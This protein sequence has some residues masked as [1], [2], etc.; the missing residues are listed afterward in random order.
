[1]KP[2][3]FVAVTSVMLCIIIGLLAFVYWTFRQDDY[4]KDSLDMLYRTEID[5]AARSLA[6]ALDEN[7]A[8]LAYYHAKTAAENAARAGLGDAARMFTDISTSL[9]ESGGVSDEMKNALGMFLESGHAPD[10]AFSE[11]QTLSGGAQ[12]YTESSVMQ[13]MYSPAQVKADGIL[14]SEKKLKMC[15]FK[16]NEAIVFSCENGYVVIDNEQ[17]PIEANMSLAHTGVALSADI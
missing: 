6:G 17:T 1:M 11:P 16:R 13:R 7:N 15:D 5:S 8:T 9:L 4:I 10:T 12:Q 14:S 2:K 3:Y